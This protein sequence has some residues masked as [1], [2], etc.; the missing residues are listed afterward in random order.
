[1]LRQVREGT[2]L[3]DGLTFANFYKQ[4]LRAKPQHTG[5]MG[6]MCYN[7]LFLMILTKA[8]S[9]SLRATMCNWALGTM[10]CIGHPHG[11]RY[12]ACDCFLYLFQ[13]C[14]RQA[15]I[16]EKTPATC[17]SLRAHYYDCCNSVLLLES[18]RLQPFHGS[19]L[20]VAKAA[21]VQL[22]TS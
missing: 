11:P 9:H 20:P 8:L 12:V 1:M 22:L 3:V 16:V 4:H 13:T 19:P 5:G 7:V 21:S 6:P 15:P 14:M 2:H 17:G 18:Q 10:A